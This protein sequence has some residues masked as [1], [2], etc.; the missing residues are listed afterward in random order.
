MTIA[1]RK[2]EELG[3]KLAAFGDGV[4]VWLKERRKLPQFRIHASQLDAIEAIL[5]GLRAGVARKLENAKSQNA[6]LARAEGIEE[7]ILAGYQIWEFYRPKLAQR[8]EPQFERFLRIADEFA[9]A[10]YQPV[11]DAVFG[12][13]E[14]AKEPPL[15]YLNPNSS[16]I[17]KERKREYEVESVPSVLL[18]RNADFVKAVAQ[19]PFPVIGVP[20]Y[21]VGFL[22][23]GLTIAHEVGHAVEA[24]CDLT[25]PIKKVAEAVSD[26]KRRSD[27]AEWAGEMFADAYGCLC[28]GPSFAYALAD[29]IA[30]DRTTVDGWQEGPYPPHSLRIFV[31]CRILERLS[32]EADGVGLWKQWSGQ[33]PPPHSWSAYA[34]DVDAIGSALLG[35]TVKRIKRTPALLRKLLAFPAKWDSV[36]KY[37]EKARKGITS[38]PPNMRVMWAASRVAYAD[39]PPAFGARDTKER[40]VSEVFFERMRGACSDD[41]RKGEQKSTVKGRAEYLHGLGES[42]AIELK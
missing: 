19:L 27:W 42:L 30:A 11:R 31:N 24:D 38:A 17:L 20:W 23:A 37:A 25:T 5:A 10:C 41:F 15:V 6:V 21:Q 14:R 7:M 36:A 40:N 26:R 18:E 32:Y 29:T 34:D 9:W 33:Y 4:D 3:Q 35:L 28:A 8:L 39:D 16:P 22:P 2:S 13:T 1:E 12:S